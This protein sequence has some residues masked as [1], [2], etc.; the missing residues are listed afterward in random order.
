M[1]MRIMPLGGSNTFG[2]YQD[3]VGPG[4]YRGPLYD[5]L[6]G[7]GADV[8]FVGLDRD[9][10]IGDPDHNGYSGQPIDWFVSPIN[11]M[12]F[13]RSGTPNVR[14][15]SGTEPGVLFLLDQAE[16]TATDVMLILLGTNDVRLGDTA[17]TMI[18]D[19]DRLLD[20]IVN[21]GRS[22]EVRLM[23]LQ[24]LGDDYWQDGD[25][26]RTNNDTIA[27]FNAALDGLAAKYAGAGV[28]LVDM[29]AGP[30]DLSPDGVH[31]SPAGYAKAARTWFDSLIEDPNLG[32]LDSETPGAPPMGSAVPP[33]QPIDFR[34]ADPT[35]SRPCA[36]QS[37]EEQGGPAVPHGARDKLRVEGAAIGFVLE[38]EGEARWSVSHESSRDAIAITGYVCSPT[39]TDLAGV[40]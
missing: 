11:Q 25:P 39:G 15:E 37:T 32:F 28:T 21:S 7:K 31:L 19:M 40:W 35:G 14:I 22:P 17:E 34:P 16:M 27:A 36:G 4:G 8:D 2:M 20:L 13:D 6:I 9:G 30:S 38:N 10:A 3:P 23:K 29:R 33:A 24:P 5:L 12:T 18:G 26:L 1:T